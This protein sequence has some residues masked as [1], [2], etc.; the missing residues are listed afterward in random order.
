MKKQMR[1]LSQIK[2]EAAVLKRAIRNQQRIVLANVERASL[3]V[4]LQDLK[5]FNEGRIDGSP[6]D[7][8]DRPIEK[9]KPDPYR[10]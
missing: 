9:S 2:R 8:L 3:L 1:T 7:F 6:H 10:V 5:D 4:K